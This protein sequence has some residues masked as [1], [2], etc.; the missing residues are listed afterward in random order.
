M[1]MPHWYLIKHT[2]YT[3][4]FA[5]FLAELTAIL[6]VLLTALFKALL[7]VLI[8]TLQTVLLKTLPTAL[9]PP[10]TSASHSIPFPALSVRKKKNNIFF[11]IKFPNTFHNN[12]FGTFPP[13]DF[14]R[15]FF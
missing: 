11:S 7:K 2:L 9:L 14:H 4:N 10:L 12:S 15:F 5:H 8:T 13:N 1:L 3:L 6:E